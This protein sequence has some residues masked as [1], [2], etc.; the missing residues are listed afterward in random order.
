MAM[1]VVM[2]DDQHV[3]E[4]VTQIVRMGGHTV[5]EFPDA[6]PALE[7]VNFGA[8]DLV[9]TDLSMPTP[10]EEAIGILRKQGIRV[11]VICLSAHMCPQK[12]ETMRQLGVT[13]FIQKPFHVDELL[14]VVKSLTWMC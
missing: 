11:P 5:L 13:R 3:R 4:V 8:V 6:A 10:G 14:D 1:V 9:I 7:K 2:D 12:V